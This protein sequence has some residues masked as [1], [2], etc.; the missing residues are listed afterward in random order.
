[1]SLACEGASVDF[2]SL[3]GARTEGEVGVE[4]IMNRERQIKVGVDKRDEEETVREFMIKY[5]SNDYL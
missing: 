1:M 3:Q 4:A 5:M 2:C